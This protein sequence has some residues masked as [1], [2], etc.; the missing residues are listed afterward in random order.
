MSQE[1]GDY[2]TQVILKK[3]DLPLGREAVMPMIDERLALALQKIVLKGTASDCDPSD[4]HTLTEYG[5]VKDNKPDIPVFTPAFEQPDTDDTLCSLRETVLKK[6]CAFLRDRCA[7]ILADCPAHL[8]DSAQIKN[9]LRGFIL[10][11]AV[12]EEAV[13]NGYLTNAAPVC[14]VYMCV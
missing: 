14:G 11:G 5:Y 4:L 13:R 1:T 3:Y 9:A 7:R 12:A 10:R 6:L 8:R 2:S